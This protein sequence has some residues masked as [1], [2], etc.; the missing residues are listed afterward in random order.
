[1]KI[2]I[3]SVRKGLEEERDSLPGL[4]K[5]LGHTPV[6]FEDFSAQPTPSRQACLDA[7]GS[8]DVCLFLLGPH[9]G[10]VFPETGQSATHDEWVAAQAAGMPRLVYRKLDV[11]FD[12]DQH[13]FTRSV[14]AYATGVFRD[15]FRNTAELQIKIVEKVKELESAALSSLTFSKL[16]QPLNL[17]WP[18]DDS[19]VHPGA[20]SPDSRLELHVVPLE[21]AGYSARELEQF[22]TSLAGRIRHTGTIRSDLALVPSRSQDYVAVS[23][24]TSQ[25]TA[26]N[27]P[28]RGELTEVRLYKTRQIS[29][30]ATLPRD[31]FGSILDPEALPQQ[32]T[33]MLKFTGAL[34]LIQQDRI[35][36]A[37]G[38]SQPSQTTVEAFN[39][40][41][42]RRTVSLAAA[43]RSLPPLQTEADEAVSLAALSAGAAEVANVLARALLAQHPS[44]T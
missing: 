28:Q 7:M 31:S 15:S 42:P 16:T 10:H 26:W 24:P 35:V 41:Q 1:M 30:L 12:P 4:I 34:G 19:G 9:Y 22:N 18:A 3:S 13:E 39:P 6:Q 36:V 8:A 44:A 33:D 20:T 17:R 32:I 27:K 23:V 29:T 43:G 37:A 21:S 25:P 5:A 2:F 11:R 38:V 40:H 14:E